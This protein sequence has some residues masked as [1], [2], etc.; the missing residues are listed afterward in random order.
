MAIVVAVIIIVV[1]GTSCKAQG[2]CDEH[3]TPQA[4]AAY[5][6]EQKEPGAYYQM[7]FDEMHENAKE[8]IQLK[9][10]FFPEKVNTTMF[11]I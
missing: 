6:N 5:P 11:F 10:Y 7:L 9:D 3:E 2:I 4:R 1:V 8:I